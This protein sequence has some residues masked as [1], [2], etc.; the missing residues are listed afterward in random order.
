M[1]DNTA[2]YSALAELQ[3]VDRKLLDEVWE[4]ARESGDPLSELLLERDLISDENLGLLVADM[5]KIP[6]VRLEK[7]VLNREVLQI[8]PEEMARARRCLIFKVDNEGTHIAMEDPTDLVTISL[9]KNKIPGPIKIYYATERDIK[10]ALFAYRREASEVFEEMINRHVG[11]AKSQPEPEAPIIRIVEMMIIYAYQSRASDIHI[12][13]YEDYIQVRFRV[14]GVLQDVIRLPLDLLNQI[15]SRIKIMS[16]LPTDE[17]SMA[18]D[19]KFVFM[20][21]DVEDVDVRVSIIPSTTGER[22]VM[23]LLAGNM[24]QYALL[25]LGFSDEDIKKVREAYSKPYGMLLSTGPTGSGKTTTMYAFIKILNRRNVNIMTIEDPVE[26]QMRGVNQIQVNSKT[27]LTFAAGLKSIVRQ[28]PN[29]ILVGEIRDEETANIAVNAALTGHLVLSTLHTNDAATTIP[30]L[31]EMKVEPFL[32]A[33]SVNM[34]VAQRLV[35][36]ICTSCRVS[37]II[38]LGDLITEFPEQEVV[39]H[40]EKE[41]EGMRVYYGKG[42]GVCRH[43][44]YVGRIGIFEVMPVTEEIRKAIV[45]KSDAEKIKKIAVAEGMQTMLENGLDKVKL[46]LTTVDELLRVIKGS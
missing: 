44:G 43:T 33:S 37:K 14:D 2:L 15:I 46:G 32:V 1:V 31:L 5:L 4:E 6:F 34:I 25:D 10:F 26:Y 22:I 29:I 40:L 19:G 13:P 38:N 8:I 28:D 23:R 20:V 12:E 16:S 3:V 41:A 18:L 45:E 17:H 35:R 11:E 9:L 27:N 21:P 39:Q 30:R 7:N 36:K 24:R 42:C